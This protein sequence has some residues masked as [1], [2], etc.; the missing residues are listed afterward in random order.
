MLVLSARIMVHGIFGS[1]E[2]VRYV[3]F[4]L[5]KGYKLGRENA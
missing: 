5:I 3:A 4:C 2:M 1:W